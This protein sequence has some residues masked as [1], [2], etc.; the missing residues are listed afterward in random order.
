MAKCSKCN[1]TEFKNNHKD[2]SELDIEEIARQA[3]EGFSSGHISD[4]EGKRIYWELK[5][6]VW[7]EK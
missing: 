4:G 2:L 1:A 3:K 6:N 7:Q 5:V